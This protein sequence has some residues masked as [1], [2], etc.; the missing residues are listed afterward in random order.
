ML[1]LFPNVIKFS[2]SASSNS[3]RFKSFNIGMDPSG[4]YGDT[5]NSGFWNG[6]TP[7]FGYT[8]YSFANSRTPPSI[9]C[10]DDDTIVSWTNV[11]FGTSFTEATEAINY[12]NSSSVDSICV[13]CDYPYLITNGLVLNYDCWF[14]PSYPKTGTS[15]YDTSGRSLTASISS[16]STFGKPGGVYL[17]NQTIVIPRDQVGTS[18]SMGSNWSFV[19][20]FSTSVGSGTTGLFSK[21]VPSN[22][23]FSIYINRNN[24][25]ISYRAGGLVDAL[26]KNSLQESTLYLLAM[27]YNSASQIISIS[28]DGVEVYTLSGVDINSIGDPDLLFGYAVD[29]KSLSYNSDCTIVSIKKYSVTLSPLDIYSILGSLKTALNPDEFTVGYTTI[30]STSNVYLFPSGSAFK[31]IPTQSG[32]VTSGGVYLI[33]NDYPGVPGINLVSLGIYSDSGIG[34]VGGPTPLDLL[35][36]SSTQESPTSVPDWVSFP[37]FVENISGGLVVTAGVPIWISVWTNAPSPVMA[38][39][40]PGSV[41]Q[42]SENSGAGAFPNWSSWNNVA[43]RDVQISVYLSVKP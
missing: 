40:D 29:S 18:F 7:T 23:G 39:S 6:I 1:N 19:F 5:K 37:S 17:K 22:N 31:F 28:I 38:F 30:G 10:H 21:S 34:S 24:L 16:G 43:L 4:S 36:Y 3:I 11:S 8:I 15:L 26:L 9:T 27:S 32:T 20:Y 33:D 13:N 2:T 42:S 14:T 12:I 35:G 41:G 25:Y